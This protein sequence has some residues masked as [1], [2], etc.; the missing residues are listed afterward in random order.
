MD[1]YQTAHLDLPD[2]HVLLK[3]LQNVS[4]DNK[5]YDFKGRSGVYKAE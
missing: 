2:L 5:T 1:P 4:V 3:R